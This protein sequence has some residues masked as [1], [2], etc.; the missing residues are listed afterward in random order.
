MLAFYAVICVLTIIYFDGTADS[1]DSVTH[2]LFARYAPDHPVLYF[3]HWAKPLFVL[4]AS[5]FAQW[6]FVG[7]K[8]FNCLI[9]LLVIFISY[10]TALELKMR[11]PILVAVILMFSPLN[12][13]LTFS[14]LTEPLFALF[15]ILGIYLCTRKKYL[16]A[17][18][19]I[20][21]LPYIR[22]EGLILAGVF[23]LFFLYKR[24]WLHLPSLLSGSVIY[25]IAGYFVHGNLLWVFT[26]IPYAKLS[27]AYGHGNLFHFVE[28]LINVTGIPIYLLFWMGFIG[29][30]ILLSR[31]KFNPE[32]HILLFA[33]FCCFFIAHSL[34][35]YLGIFNSMGL[36][37]VLIG[38]LP[39][40]A[41]ISL[42]GFNFISEDLLALKPVLKKAVQVGLVGYILVFP[43]TPNP[44]AIQWEK[45]MML[46]ADQ[47]LSIKTFEFLSREK[48]IKGPVLYNYH[49]FSILLNIDYF[50]SRFHKPISL[51]AIA[52]MH[53]GDILIWDNLYAAFESGIKKQDLDSL[54]QLSNLC[55]YKTNE[56]GREMIFSVYEKKQ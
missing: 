35:W 9:S 54:P 49:Y 42:Q 27:S 28:E 6:G 32:Q 8:V 2:Y 30:I 41:L 48:K 36:K 20:S 22:S 51:E 11:N 45:D 12:Y 3:D 50:D 16:L 1:G 44:S 31:K 21:F 5:P 53:S 23:A 33:G 56:R 26:K 38:I 55:I 25:G 14:G 17:C 37:R 7:M 18:F 24:K 34:F 43:F 39:I 46:N 40:I 13:I 47:K 15:T 19:I 4:L 29:L 52:E 10:K